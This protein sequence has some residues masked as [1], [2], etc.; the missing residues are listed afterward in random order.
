MY[1]SFTPFLL[2]GL[3]SENPPKGGQPPTVLV[4]PV[5]ILPYLTDFVN[6]AHIFLWFYVFLLCFCTF[7]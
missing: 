7:N 4:T 2:Y 6:I 5:L 3:E 1:I